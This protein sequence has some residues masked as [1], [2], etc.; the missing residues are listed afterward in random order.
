MSD[1]ELLPAPLDVPGRRRRP[2]LGLVVVAAV[3]EAARQ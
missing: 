2:R 3:I 1:D